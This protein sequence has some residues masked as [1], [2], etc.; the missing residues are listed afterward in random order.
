MALDW[1]LATS[2]RSTTMVCS[3]NVVTRA[4]A[5]PTA[6]QLDVTA[7]PP[8]AVT[9]TAAAL[10]APVANATTSR[11]A[12]GTVTVMVVPVMAPAPTATTMD[13][14]TAWPGTT[15]SRVPKS[16]A[17]VGTGVVR[18]ANVVPDSARVGELPCSG[19]SN[20][21]DP[22]GADG[23]VEYRSEHDGVN[24]AAA[25]ALMRITYRS[26]EVPAPTATA[27]AGMGNVAREPP[28]GSDSEPGVTATAAPPEGSTVADTMV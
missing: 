21:S 28:P 5:S 20:V 10:P 18:P 3:L 17:S 1:S 24:T 2:Q 9:C 23:A 25:P 13:H 4:A 22:A 7:E 11:L 6:P 27:E 16:S 19:A 15:V 26:V 8:V 12:A 14:R